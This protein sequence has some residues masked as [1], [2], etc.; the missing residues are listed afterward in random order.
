MKMMLLS[1]IQKD[2]EKKDY[3][4]VMIYFTMFKQYIIYR[5]SN[6]INY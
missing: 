6:T 2:I 3:R 5:T 1:Y 4:Q